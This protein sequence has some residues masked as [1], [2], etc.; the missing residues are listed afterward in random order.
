MKKYN[1]VVCGGTFD[2]FHKG[3]REF[4]RYV[5]S[6]GKKVIVGVTS[7]EYVKNSKFN[8]STSLRTRIQNSKFV[9]P[10][11]KRK[12]AVS[13]F[14]ESRGVL[15]GVETVEI[16]DLFGPTLD[17]S[18]A[19]DAI[20]VAKDTKEGAE[21]ISCKRKEL[22]LSPLKIFIVPPIKAKD[23]RLISSERIRNGEINREGKLYV[24]DEWF[25]NNL[26]LPEDLRKK[27]QKPYG[28]LFKDVKDSFKNKSSLVITVGDVTTKKFNEFK[29][30]QQ[31]SV[32]DFKVAREK[33]F[34]NII[35]L[36]F[37]GTEK[38]FKVDNPAGYI[39]SNLLIALA[40]VFKLEI[41]NE[42]V[43]QINGEEDLTV[44]PLILMAPLGAVIFY[45]QPNKG[46]V[47]V[48]VSEGNK[49]RAYKLLSRF[50]AIDR[51]Y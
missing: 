32:I 29:L 20:V 19:I 28:E 24:K 3:H 37:S 46:I 47:K 14:I 30:N 7:D 13:E 39:T 27:F 33:K 15:G 35:E 23:G 51:D 40:K 22:D 25:S 16:N 48:K 11:R 4:L 18:L 10:F 6:V 2:H 26:K 9:E 21:Y 38:I 41:K 50:R 43:L 5:F 1:L 44:L 45:G 42:I 12:Q 34:S 49:D 8:P 36:G 17:K 31:I